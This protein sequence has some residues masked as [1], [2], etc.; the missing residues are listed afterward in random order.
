MHFGHSFA[1]CESLEIEYWVF[2]TNVVLIDA[3]YNNLFENINP[4]NNFWFPEH[5]LLVSQECF[6]Y[7]NRRFCLG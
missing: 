7:V 6:L 3:N 5:S 2:E 1:S 4:D